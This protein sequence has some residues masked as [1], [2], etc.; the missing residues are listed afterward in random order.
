[1]LAVEV[2]DLVP[3]LRAVHGQLLENVVLFPCR[4]EVEEVGAFHLLLCL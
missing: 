3:E 1:L 2:V 4:C